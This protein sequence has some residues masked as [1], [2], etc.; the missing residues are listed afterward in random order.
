MSN[1]WANSATP[2]PLTF[3]ALRHSRSRPKNLGKDD[4]TI[5][6]S[7]SQTQSCYD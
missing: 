5:L 2:D 4:E 6:G 3:F 1:I 7:E